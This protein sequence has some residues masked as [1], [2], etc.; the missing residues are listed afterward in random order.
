MFGFSRIGFHMSPKSK[1]KIGQ[2]K[3]KG[4]FRHPCFKTLILEITS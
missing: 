1:I 3:S 4:R 2:V